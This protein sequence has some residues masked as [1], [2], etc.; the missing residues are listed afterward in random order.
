MR[1]QRHG[2]RVQMVTR[3]LLLLSLGY[4]A[5]SEV[6]VRFPPPPPSLIAPGTVYRFDGWQ[7]QTCWKSPRAVQGEALQAYSSKHFYLEK[8][9][10]VPNAT[11]STAAIVF[12]T[13]DNCSVHTAHSTHPRTELRDLS[14]DD[15]SWPSTATPPT[16]T[17][18]LTATLVV[19]HAAAGKPET[20]IAQIHG[21]VNEERAKIVKLRWTGGLVEARVKKPDPPYDEIGLPLGHYNCG[22]VLQYEIVADGATGKLVVTVNGK[23][24]EYSPPVNTKDRFYFKAGNYNQCNGLCNPS[25]YA[26][27]RFHAVNATHE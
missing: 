25:D 20:V 1:A 2:T 4:V 5:S 12:V 8:S 22:D 7:L 6:P 14:V 19:D 17:H 9:W 3:R 16:T 23:Q 13:P 18:R 15:W 24:V 11:A 27:V 21:S 10:R 26:K